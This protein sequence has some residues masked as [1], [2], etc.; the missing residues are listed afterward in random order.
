[1][2]VGIDSHKDTLAACGVDHL[3]RQNIAG[4]FPNTSDGH[5][6]LLSWG[7]SSGPTMIWAIEGSGSHGAPVA[8]FLLACGDRV[9]EVPANLTAA[10][11]KHVRPRGKSDPADALAIARVAAREEE[12]PPVSPHGPQDELRLLVDYRQQLMGERTRIANR[13][14]Q[15]LALTAP[16]YQARCRKLNS[17]RALGIA[18]S[19]LRPSPTMRARLGLRRI[20]RLRQLD[21]EIY[22]L[23]KEIKTHVRATGTRL[24]AIPGVGALV[25]ARIIAEVGEVGRFRSRNH[26]AA[27][28][29]TAPV[30]AS[31]GRVIRHRLNRTGNRQLNRALHTVALTQARIDPRARTYLTRKLQ[32][33]KSWKESMRCLKRRLSD[34]VYRQLVEDARERAALDMT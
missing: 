28:N 33:G 18:E 17:L 1:L 7:R 13:L 34:V 6:Q 27:M 9:I 11:R 23:E 32:E 30:P 29:G 8:Q 15:D 12:L 19:I 20:G 24:T 16:G 22:E 26:F 31:S 4:V 5:G 10:E 3:G 14:H 25:A 2:I 21:R